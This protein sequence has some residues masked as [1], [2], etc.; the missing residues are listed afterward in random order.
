MRLDLFPYPFMVGV[1]ILVILNLILR[2]K[3]RSWTYLFFFSAFGLYM[4]ILIGLVVFPIPLEP[5]LKLSEL[6]TS[7]QAAIPRIY[8]LPHD[9]GSLAI[10]PGYYKFEILA[11][12]FLTIPFGF[13]VL[14]VRPSLSNKMLLTALLV[15]V[16]DE[17]AQFLLLLFWGFSYRVVDINDVFLNSLGVLIGY[18]LFVIFTWSLKRIVKVFRIQPT[19][20]LKYMVDMKLR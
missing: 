20:I 9:Y 13:L 15:G 2:I 4:L 6:W 14:W 10:Y 1:G 19:G 7:L 5:P 11:N 18:F 8:L 12:V 3:R 16:L 17:A